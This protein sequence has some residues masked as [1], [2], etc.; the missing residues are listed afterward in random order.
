[1]SYDALEVTTAHLRELAAKHG[2]AVAEMTSAT[3]A[4]AG[5]D[6]RIRMSH[7]VVAWSTAAALEAIQQARAD[8]AASVAGESRALEENLTCAAHR[9]E[10]TDQASAERLRR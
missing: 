5:V 3:A 4:V 6:T 8:A 10:S 2:Q 7:G 1:M 9:Y